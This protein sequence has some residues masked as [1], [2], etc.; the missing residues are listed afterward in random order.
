MAAQQ[1]QLNADF[2]PTTP[3]GSYWEFLQNLWRSGLDDDDSGEK[4]WTTAPVGEAAFFHHGFVRAWY[5]TARDGALRKKAKKSLSVAELC[6]HCCRGSPMPSSITPTPGDPGEVV[7]LAIFG[8]N[9]VMDEPGR[10]G[11]T[12]AALE[13]GP[14]RWLLDPNDN[15]RR[16]E[17]Q[18]IVKY[19]R[20]RGD[21]EAVL[22]FDWRAQ[23]CSF[24]LRCATVPLQSP[25]NAS[26]VPAYQRLSTFS[27]ALYHSEK[28]KHVP[29]PAVREASAVCEALAARLVDPQVARDQVRIC[30]DFKLLGGD[31]IVLIWAATASADAVFP[32][33]AFPAS[34]PAA[35]KLPLSEPP[36]KQPVNVQLLLPQPRRPKR[37]DDD[38]DDPSAS[39][40]KPPL[41]S[42]PN[43]ALTPAPS[44]AARGATGSARRAPGVG[45][46]C[47][48]FFVCRGCGRTEPRHLAL[49]PERD[50][51]ASRSIDVHAG[52]VSSGGSFSAGMGDSKFRPQ[53]AQLP[54]AAVAG[55]MPSV[56]RP[57]SA[58][59]S[60]AARLA[61]PRLVVRAD[62][63]GVA[64]VG[65]MRGTVPGWQQTSMCKAC[66][67]EQPEP[68]VGERRLALARGDAARKERIE[69]RRVVIDSELGR[70]LAASPKGEVEPEEA[71]VELG[72]APRLPTD[73]AGD[74]EPKDARSL[75]EMARQMEA[76]RTDDAAAADAAAA[77]V[78]AADVAAAGEDLRAGSGDGGE[79]GA[80]D[81]GGAAELPA[82][83][84]EE[85]VAASG[86]EGAEGAEGGTPAVAREAE[87]EAEAEAVA[88]AEA[89]VAPPAAPPASELASAPGAAPAS[90]ASEADEN[91]HGNRRPLPPPPQQGKHPR[92][93]HPRGPSAPRWLQQYLPQE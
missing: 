13:R 71:A 5:F 8:P 58:T 50:L 22:R 6:K 35:A 12:V 39:S 42:R 15:A 40:R 75:L 85:E 14:L 34:M 54:A 61:S 48:R 2:S 57:T 69:Q 30:A 72:K 29:P 1:S 73:E 47:S 27:P 26:I 3:D 19:V 90:A 55:G 16:R 60:A 9:G 79:G 87:A 78:A 65:P 91:K 89:D 38:D 81:V 43:M 83:A 44:A 17:L 4:P 77:D 49:Q 28:E 24:E 67:A 25:S 33:H 32:A 64:N 46:M 84:A 10:R 37:S 20:P 82:D 41:T 92:G 59:V 63:I 66:Y 70:A 45:L 56:G 7:A 31:K 51:L 88:V 68:A 52:A 93:K 86:A 36:A 21:R 74:D 80:A 11:S 76:E 18:A 53:S 23:V 62:D